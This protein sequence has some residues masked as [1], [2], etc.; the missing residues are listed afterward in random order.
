MGRSVITYSD[1]S[2][3]NPCRSPSA[4]P[5]HLTL[6]FHPQAFPSNPY[7]KCRYRQLNFHPSSY[8]KRIHSTSIPKKG[9]MPVITYSDESIRNPCRSPSAFPFHLTLPFH[10]QAFPSNPYGK[11]R[12]RQLNFHPSSYQKRIH[13][14]SIPKKG[15]MPVITY[16]D[17]LHLFQAQN[18]SMILFHSPLPIH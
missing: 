14:T 12:Y 3:R 6:P 17:V 16:S 8:Q 9:S 5:F 10:P 1:E 18:L 4:F 15:S 13:S 7:G 11:C 2:I